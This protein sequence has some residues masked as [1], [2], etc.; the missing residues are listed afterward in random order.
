L[1]QK[2]GNVLEFY[3]CQETDQG[4]VGTK[5][6]R[7]KWLFVMTVWRIMGKIIRTIIM[8]ITYAE[9]QR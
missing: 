5:Y 2:P 9:G 3:E 8:L 7:G 4:I 6:G 1:T